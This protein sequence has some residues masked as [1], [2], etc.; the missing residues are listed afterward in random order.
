MC[1]ANTD[2]SGKQKAL[3]LCRY[4]IS[5]NKATRPHLSHQQGWVGTLKISLVLVLAIYRIAVKGAVLVAAWNRG[6]F[7]Q[8]RSPL[9]KAA[10]ARLGGLRAVVAADDAHPHSFA[11]GAELWHEGSLH[12]IAARDG[13]RQSGK[14]GRCVE[15]YF[16]AD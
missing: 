14:A 16:G 3:A 2:R 8:V 15:D 11:S 5:I 7:Q 6:A 1:F 4:R 10:L 12:S 9:L 13:T